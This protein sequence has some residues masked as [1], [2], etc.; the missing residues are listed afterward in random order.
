MRSMAGRAADS[1]GTVAPLETVGSLAMRDLPGI[2]VLQ[3]LAGF[4]GL[5]PILALP[6]TRGQ[7][8]RGGDLLAPV[9]P[10]FLLRD[11]RPGCVRT[12]EFPIAERPNTVALTV[13]DMAIV[14]SIAIPITTGGVADGTP[15]RT[16]MRTRD[17]YIR[18]LM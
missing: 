9:L 14:G 15:A 8:L 11:K 17:I 3:V 2:P 16:A 4:R 7:A 6:D 5:R 18:I 1:Q 10:G 12:G 13:L